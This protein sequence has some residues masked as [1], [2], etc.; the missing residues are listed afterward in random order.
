MTLLDMLVQ[1]HDHVTKRSK[2]DKVNGFKRS[3]VEET[4]GGYFLNT[5][6][7]SICVYIC[8]LI[9]L[10]LD[11]MRVSRTREPSLDM[12]FTISFRKTNGLQTQSIRKMIDGTMSSS[13]AN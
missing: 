7:S 1:E 9:V 12:S 10:C 3:F 11:C 6:K 2:E 8:M 13:H 4:F 5:G